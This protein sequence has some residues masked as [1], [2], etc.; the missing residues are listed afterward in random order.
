MGWSPGRWI[1]GPLRAARW[2][3]HGA[4]GVLAI[5]AAKPF[6][7]AAALVTAAAVTGIGL[8]THHVLLGHRPEPLPNLELTVPQVVEETP[9]STVTASGSLSAGQQAAKGATAVGQQLTDSPAPAPALPLDS[10]SDP[11]RRHAKADS[12]LSTV[13]SM[14]STDAP[15]SHVNKSEQG[16]AGLAGSDAAM[17]LSAG[18]SSTGFVLQPQDPA[19]A[20]DSDHPAASTT[21]GQATGGLTLPVGGQRPAPVRQD[22]PGVT[23]LSSLSN[24][25]EQPVAPAPIGNSED[26]LTPNAIAPATG[27]ASGVGHLSENQPA[28]QG[29]SNGATEV[30]PQGVG[31]A[32]GSAR[33]GQPL[34][35]GPVPHSSQEQTDE[36]ADASSRVARDAS[37]PGGVR[38]AEFA[39]ASP[40]PPASSAPESALGSGPSSAVPEGGGPSLGATAAAGNTA[41][42]QPRDAKQPGGGLVL[43][44]NAATNLRQGPTGESKESRPKAARPTAPTDRSPSSSGSSSPG[45]SGVQR[46]TANRAAPPKVVAPSQPVPPAGAPS[47][48]GD[49]VNLLQGG[50]PSQADSAVTVEVQGP[51]EV[52]LGQPV[53]YGL[54]VRNASRIPMTGV[55]VLAQLNGPFG[56]LQTDPPAQQNGA[57]LLWSVGTLEPAETRVLSVTATPVAEGEL[58]IGARVLLA[59]QVGNRTRV[60]QPRLTLV[61]VG[62]RRVEVGETVRFLL[63]V[64]NPGTGV[65]RNVVIHDQLSDAFQHPAGSDIEYVVGDLGPGQTR[66]VPLEVTATRAGTFL[67][68]AVAKAEGGLEATAEATVEVVQAQLVLSKTGP[69]KRY[70]G[71]EVTYV[72]SLENRGTAPAR[73]V[74]L[75]DSLPAGLM[76]AEPP[77]GASWDEAK[78]LLSWNMAVLEP[79]GSRRFEVRCTAIRG[80]E[81]VNKAVATAQGGLRAEAE[82]RTLVEGVPALLLEVVDTDDPLEVGAETTYEIRIVNQGTRP[83]VGLELTVAIPDGM[84]FVAA[85]APAGFHLEGSELRF[86]SVPPIAP[87]A[88]GA[89][90]V[91]LRGLTPGD[92]RLRVHLR[93][94]AFGATVLEEESTKVYDGR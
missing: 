8:L 33:G 24:P 2:V 28:L 87:K 27:N 66:E 30:G 12:A 21:S 42:T 14:T 29:M 55:Q 10:G 68:R 90:Y 78:R 58:A 83:I 34:A 84:E 59:T 23:D 48:E 3:S 70:I 56:E 31:A 61:K 39:Q 25:D 43:D 86:D 36:G 53:R 50:A 4:G 1:A 41:E 88:S 7:V 91:R 72:L 69:E 89:F 93:A 35:E 37:S 63:T 15:V 77:A 20:L 51:P 76:L 92:K 18:S 60:T 47:L 81:Q 19:A 6:L 22:S 54:R 52:R 64:A 71:S 65:A 5:A 44:P 9:S 82:A 85:E 67:N 57:T 17:E 40:S 80:G 75:V 74:L 11:M 49:S 32:P 46:A 38:P 26:D 79:G 13:T 16:T 62:P 73:S 45:H 94:G